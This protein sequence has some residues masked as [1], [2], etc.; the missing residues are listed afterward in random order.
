MKV[1]VEVL[2]KL[3]WFQDEK[4]LR[5]GATDLSKKESF[6]ARNGGFCIFAAVQSWATSAG[7][8]VAWIGEAGTWIAGNWAGV[9]NLPV[10]LCHS[11]RR[12]MSVTA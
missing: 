1:C 9:N 6:V 2:E 11:R 12:M 10:P 3:L 7:L 5:V 4:T 8:R